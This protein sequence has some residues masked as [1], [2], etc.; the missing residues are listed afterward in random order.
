MRTYGASTITGRFGYSGGA[1]CPVKD[2]VM[3]GYF[4][5]REGESVGE[6]L[7]RSS[8]SGA[9]RVTPGRLLPLEAYGMVAGRAASAR[10][11]IAK[12]VCA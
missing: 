7:W 11:S 5:G 1:G 10:L 9:T 3:T 8:W 12:V 6:A 4:Y 2:V